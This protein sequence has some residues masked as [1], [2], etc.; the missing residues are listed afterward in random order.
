[1][2]FEIEFTEKAKED[3][4]T[5]KKAGNVILLKKIA[6]LIKE[7]AENPFEGTGKPEL[8]KYDLSGCWS[9]R[10]NKEHRL[11]YEVVGNIVYILSTYG[12]Y[13]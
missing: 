12:H 4:E 11:V 3:I 10:I 7:I 9:R 13:I 6:T 8:L 5:L 1:M 2:S